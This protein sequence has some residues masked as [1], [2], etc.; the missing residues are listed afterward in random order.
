VDSI[1]TDDA[2]S[3]EQNVLKSFC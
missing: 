1:V 2:I 3:L